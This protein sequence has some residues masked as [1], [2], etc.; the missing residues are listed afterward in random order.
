MAQTDLLCPLTG[1]SGGG[2]SAFLGVVVRIE[3]HLGPDGERY[4]TRAHAAALKGVSVGALDGWV[5][6][7]YLK[8]LEG[9]PP[10]RLMFNLSDVDA[11]ELLA[12]QAALRT[13]GSGK[14]VERA[15]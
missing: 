5:R 4:V 14:R 2:H 1:I 3:A 9:C 10:R 7:G 15:A 8:P 11:A 12:Y 13:S 6:K